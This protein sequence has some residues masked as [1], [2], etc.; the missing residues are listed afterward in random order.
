VGIKFAV[1]WADAIWP[2]ASNVSHQ[3]PEAYF[4]SIG[5][6]LNGKQGGIFDAAFDPTQE[7]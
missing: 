7:S 5:Y 2:K 6:G 1:D 4:K 3:I